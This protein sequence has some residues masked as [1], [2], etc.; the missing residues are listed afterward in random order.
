MIFVPLFIV[1]V[2]CHFDPMMSLDALKLMKN[3]LEE[4][5]LL[6]S[7]HLMCQPLAFK[8]PDAGKKT[9]EKFKNAEFSVKI[10]KIFQ[11]EH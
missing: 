5:G 6:D 8:T 11:K 10:K 3:G 7:V 1:G 2:N 4:A 9:R